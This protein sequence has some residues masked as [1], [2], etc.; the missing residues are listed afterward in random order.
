MKKIVLTPRLQKIADFI[1]HNSRLADIGT[2]HGY[3]PVYCVLE[4]RCTYVAA[5]DIRKGPLASAQNTAKSFEAEDSISFFCAPGL[6]AISPGTVDTI[7]IAGM[8]GETII[9]ILSQAHW[10]KDPAIRIILQPQ[11][12]QLLLQ[13]WLEANSFFADSA[14]LVEDSHRVYMVGAFHYELDSTQHCAPFWLDIIDDGFLRYTYARSLCHRIKREISGLERACSSQD[15]E[16]TDSAPDWDFD[17]NAYCKRLNRLNS[18]KELKFLLDR[19]KTY[20]PDE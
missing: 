7:V 11:S 9:K 18:V 17:T 20:L 3:I 1:P 2:D 4:G 14:V 12:K 13:E 6:E 5:S 19:I 8:G 10:I 15:A 16:L